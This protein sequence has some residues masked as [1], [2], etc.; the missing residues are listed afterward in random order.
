MSLTLASPKGRDCGK[1]LPA[2][3]LVRSIIPGEQEN[4]EGGEAKKEEEHTGVGTDL[5]DHCAW[6][7]YD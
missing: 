4:R 5:I 7:H 6:F 2:A 3:A 1:C